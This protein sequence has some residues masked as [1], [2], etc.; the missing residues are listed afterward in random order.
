[1]SAQAALAAR[2]RE[3]VTLE[4]IAGLLSWDREVMMPAGAAG[5]RA[6]QA[7]LLAGLAHERRADPA[8]GDLIAMAQA[9]P[10]E[11]PDAQ[12]LLRAAMRLHARAARVPRRLAEALAETTSRAQGVWAAARAA[13]DPAPFLP[14]LAEVVALTREE[15]QALAEG[16]GIDAYDALIDGYEP[17]ARAAGIAALFAEL[18]PPLVALRERVLG[19]GRTP[20]VL[21][22]HF[23]AAAQMALAREIAQRFGYDF[24]RGRLDLSVHPFT[25]GGGAHDIRITSRVDEADPF[26]CLFSTIH[27]LGHALYE[28]AIDPALAGTPLGT[29][30]S[31]GVHESQS[32]L[33]E[34]QIGRGRAFAGWLWGEMRARFGDMG[35]ADADAFH[36]A[37]NRVA[38]GFIR[39]EADELHYNLHIMLRFDLER[40][41][42]AGRLDVADLEEAWR[43]R[44]AA[45]FGTPPPRPALGFLQDVHWSAGLFGYFPTYTLGNVHAAALW[46]ALRADLPDLDARLASGDP[47]PAMGWLAERVQ[48][49]GGRM[50]PQELMA[51][52]TGGPM[53]AAPLVGY[54]EEKFAALYRL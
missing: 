26:N 18:R 10:P 23:P 22:G 33:V 1:M 44:F 8:L 14:L 31:M 35:I 48:R 34:N 39:T 53:S 37:L 15:G 20:P 6:A 2:L 17:E 19:A 11:G 25:G 45:D 7:A 24:A 30:V 46:A 36:A 49:H 29:G 27:E 9:E 12:A 4:G 40:D 32:R 42:I 50:M 43:V 13:D 16:Q 47:R 3:V 54:L 5:T 41:L 21:S 28:Q 51:Q 38:P 52:A